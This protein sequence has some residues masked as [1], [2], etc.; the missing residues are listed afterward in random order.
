MRRSVLLAALSVVTVSLWTQSGAAQPES[1]LSALVG[2][3]AALRDG[4]TA[5]RRELQEIKSLLGA[6]PERVG[7]REG[8]VFGGLDDSQRVALVRALAA[9]PAGTPV[10]FA[11]YEQDPAA[12]E[13]V[14]ALRAAFAEARW[15]VR[16]VRRVSFALKSGVYLLAADEEPPAYVQTA[17]AAL[18]LAGIPATSA[19]GYR[20]YYAEMRGKPGWRGFTMAPNQ[21]YLVVVGPMAER[22]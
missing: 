16:G 4:Q 22:P 8:A 13:L 7:T 1:E 3:F 14:R 15:A 5:I 10:W 20:S 18:Q 17:Q 11:V 9:Q 6:N 12:R 2:D 19:A 21:T